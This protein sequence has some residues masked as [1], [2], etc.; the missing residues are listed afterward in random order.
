MRLPVSGPRTAPWL[1]LLTLACVPLGCGGDGE[2]SKHGD[3]PVAGAGAGNGPGP[4][5]C[6]DDEEL[7]EGQ[8]VPISASCELLGCAKEGRVCDE[9]PSPKCG[10]C[11]SDRG[12]V[13]TAGGKCTLISGACESQ[14]DCEDGEYCLKLDTSVNR[15]AS[16]LVPPD[17]VELE[18]TGKAEARAWDPAKQA[19]IDCGSC[20]GVE[21]STG[22]LWPVTASGSCICETSDG[23]YFDA[24]VATRAP[25]ACDADADGWVENP[26]RDAIESSDVAIRSNAH[27]HVRSIGNFVLQNERGERRDVTLGELGVGADVLDLFEPRALDSAD[28]LDAVSERT[29]EYGQRRFAANELNPLTK[30]CVDPRADYNQDGLFDIEQR[31]SQSPGG[32]DDWLLPFVKL[33]YFVELDQGYFVAGDANE[34]GSYVI[35]EKRRCDS[36]QFLFDYGA[37]TESGY[38]KNCERRR[39]SDF[40]AGEPWSDFARFTCKA[41]SGSCPATDPAELFDSDQ[42][43]PITLIPLHQSCA[44]APGAEFSGMNHGSQFRCVQ[45]QDNV[46][47]PYGVDL[48]AAFEP[49]EAGSYVANVCGISGGESPI[50]GS[51]DAIEAAISCAPASHSELTA[52]QVGWALSTFTPYEQSQNYVRGCMAEGAEWPQLCPGQASIGARAL[53]NAFDFGNLYCGCGTNFGGTNC[54]IACAPGSVAD[55]Q[56]HTGGEL[57]PEWSEGE[58]ASF[59]C[60]AA[61]YCTNVV[62]QPGD[63]SCRPGRSGYWMCS[64]L[65]ATTGITTPSTADTWSLTSASIP[66]SAVDRS[67]PMCDPSSA[68]CSNGYS[69]R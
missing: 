8:C 9:D 37:A 65:A 19:C 38:W 33:A 15:P 36:D 27:C 48:A 14:A 31:Q 55:T 12:Y 50:G 13:E 46:S 20:D 2:G 29:P 49:G 18:P 57:K 69:L 22:R 64:T 25:R 34:P 44:S 53:S 28:E 30:A 60:D 45:F 63:A 43:D 52:G 7:V 68:D 66:Y 4:E 56:Q 41:A 47:T 40:N 59:S 1:L 42:V 10:L 3:T 17:C 67:K 51:D 39:A 23:Y 54:E 35:A 6:A 21:G 11:D 5:P 32:N 16:C 62:C 61:G 58:R 26:A 24:S